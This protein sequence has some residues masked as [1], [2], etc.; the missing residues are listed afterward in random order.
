MPMAEEV[1]SVREALESAFEAAET[2]AAPPPARAPRPESKPRET[3][4]IAREAPAEIA[5]AEPANQRQEPEPE[6]PERQVDRPRDQFGRFQ[7]ATPPAPSERAIAQPEGAEKSPPI[8]EISDQAQLEEQ[9]EATLPILPPQSWS[10]TAKDNW[11]TLPRAIQ[12]EVDR[13]ER[14]VQR[15]FR[16]RA[17][18]T[19][20]LEPL[21]QAIQPYSQKLALRGVHP[22]AAV[23]QLLAVQDLLESNPIEGIAHVA[24]A[25]GVDLRQY[26]TAFAQ[27]Q[28]PVDPNVAAA[29]D[30][31]GKLESMLT[32]WQQGA[33][34]QEQA[35]INAEVQAFAA[36]SRSHP[37]FEHV[38]MRM[39]D[40]MGKGAADTL[41]QA[42][43]IACAENEDITR[44]MSQSSRQAEQAA[45][46]R[47]EAQTADRARRA[48][49][50][51]HGS[52]Y[53]GGQAP[54]SGKPLSVRDAIASAMEQVAER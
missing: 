3:N 28:Q 44:A 46:R 26:A 40:L 25:Y 43:K 6:Q 15:A 47:A 8:S 12:E 20:V 34:Q 18:Q 53:G 48:A 31:I 21:A 19:N 7:R 1:Q 54:R 2:P 39:A 9:E 24:R 29:N 36:D 10:A 5:E 38:R 37:Y 49:V 13:R 17:E 45:R 42:Y 4:E 22:A 35:R 52:P 14:D 23:Q 32:S 16:E 51:V 33:Q 11:A 50:S 30:R 27:A 41:A